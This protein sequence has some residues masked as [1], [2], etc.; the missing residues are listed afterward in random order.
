MSDTGAGSGA[1][2]FERDLAARGRLLYTGD[3]LSARLA[4]ARLTEA[5]LAAASF[6]GRRVIDIGCGDGTYSVELAAL[7]RPARLHGV[8]PAAV[9]VHVA[10]R[11]AE[12]RDG[13]SFEVGSAHALRHADGAFDL[14]VLRGVLHHVDRPAD[15]LREALRVASTVVVVEPNGLNPGLKMLER[16]SRYHREHDERSYPPSVLDG[17]VVA[18]GAAVVRREWI[19]FVPMFSWDRYARVAKLI[20]PVVEGL[21]GLRTIACAQYVFAASRELSFTTAVPTVDACDAC[22]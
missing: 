2:P 19:G 12:G 17:W 3:R 8:D 13:L 11:Q 14:A 4:N 1:R 18:S 7:G 21:P 16:T 5:V 10:R 6:E 9:A 22:S 20:E 15:A